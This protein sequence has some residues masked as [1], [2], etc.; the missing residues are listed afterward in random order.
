MSPHNRAPFQSPQ[1]F[2]LNRSGRSRIIQA[3][4]IASLLSRQQPPFLYGFECGR[5]SPGSMHG[6]E[7]HARLDDGRIFA[8]NCFTNLDLTVNR[9]TLTLSYDWW[10][11]EKFSAQLRL[12]EGNA[13][14]W[15]PSDSAF[16]LLAEAARGKIANDFNNIPISNNTSGR[17]MKIDQIINKA[18]ARRQSKSGSTKETLKSRRRIHDGDFSLSE[19][20]I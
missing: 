9:G 13:W 15:L 12:A 2:L 14:L 8:R 7:V 20:E 3:R 19:F 4:L 18:E 10:E 16:H 1:K 5:G 17:G 11:Q 6:R